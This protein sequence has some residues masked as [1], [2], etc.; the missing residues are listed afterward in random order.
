M[1]E[2]KYEINGIS[3]FNVRN[4]NEIKVIQIMKKVL[5]DYPDFDQCALCFQD[6]YA[7][8][9]NQIPA[10][11]IQMGTIILKKVDNDAEIEEIVRASYEAVIKQPK[12]P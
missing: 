2:E 10:H 5:P 11:Y 12:H 3:L 9:L 1:D 4:R 8:T 7:L 6:V